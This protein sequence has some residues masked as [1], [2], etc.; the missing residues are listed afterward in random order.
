[1]PRP[2]LPIVENAGRPAADVSGRRPEVIVDFALDEG[3]LF[4]VLRNIGERS[5][6]RVETRFDP[7]FNGLGGEKCISRLA[8]FKRVEFMAPGKQFVQHVDRLDAYFR[9][10]E[11]ARLMA[12]VTYRDRE[13]QRFED[14]IPH[15]LR[16]FRDLGESRTR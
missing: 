12:T 2:R 1:M 4:V 3:L 13:G 11:P 9:R 14:V 10:K 5:A 7:A 16:I 8:L 6:Y 15:D